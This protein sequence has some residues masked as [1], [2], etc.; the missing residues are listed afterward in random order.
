MIIRVI[1]AIVAL[2]AATVAVVAI[3]PVFTGGVDTPAVMMFGV[4]GVAAFAALRY[5][6]FPP[7]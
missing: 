7:K 3:T 6:V 1:G 4:S 2:L 5:L